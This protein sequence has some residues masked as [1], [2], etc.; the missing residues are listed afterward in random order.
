MTPLKYINSGA[1]EF[2]CIYHRGGSFSSRT[3]SNTTHRVKDK[4]NCYGMIL[5]MENVLILGRPE[6]D[7]VEGTKHQQKIK[8]GEA[9]QVNPFSSAEAAT[10][11]KGFDEYLCVQFCPMDALKRQEG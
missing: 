10:S 1:C 2:A 8:E 4:R 9:P 11:W 5:E 7:E 6:G 3:S